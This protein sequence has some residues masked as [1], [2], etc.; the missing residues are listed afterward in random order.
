M[1]RTARLEGRRGDERGKK[2]SGWSEQV[3]VRDEMER[4][5]GWMMIDGGERRVEELG[6]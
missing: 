5:G 2:R 4:E 1:A 3:G 6:R